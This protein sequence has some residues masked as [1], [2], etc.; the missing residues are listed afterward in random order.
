MPRIHAGDSRPPRFHDENLVD[1]AFDDPLVVFFRIEAVEGKLESSLPLDA[2]VAL[3]GVAAPFG[4][5]GG[6]VAVKSERSRLRA[7]ADS[8][9]RTDL[10]SSVLDL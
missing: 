10:V 9:P 8:N 1:P 3:A 2:A 6:D 5:Y 4:Q 7:C